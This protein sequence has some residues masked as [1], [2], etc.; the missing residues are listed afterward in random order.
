MDIEKQEEN[1]LTDSHF[2]KPIVEEIEKIITQREILQARIKI[3][4]VK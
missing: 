3:M 2:W 4:G 1:D